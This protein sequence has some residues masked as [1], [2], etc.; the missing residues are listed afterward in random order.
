ML[1]IFKIVKREFLTKVFTRGFIISTILGPV[2]MI[3]IILAPAYFITLGSDK[4]VRIGILDYTATFGEPL[5]TTFQD[6]LNTGERKFQFSDIDIRDYTMQTVN[7]LSLVETGEFKGIVVIPENVYESDSV[8]FMAKTVSDL[9]LVQ[10]LRNGISSIVRQQRLKL[11]NLDPVKIGQLT[12]GISIYTIKVYEGTETARGFGEEYLTAMI[13]LVILYMTILIYGSSIMRSVIEEKSSRIIEI[14]LSSCNS[15][16][17]MMG[18][19]LGVGAVGLVQYVIWVTMGMGVFVIV[20]NTMPAIA[21]SIT[22]STTALLFFVIFFIIGFFTF[23]TLYA[24]VGAMCSDM[25]DAQSVSIPVTLLIVLPFLISFMVIRDPASEISQILS[26]LP[27]FT[28]LI[29]F[30]RVLLIHPPGIE[31][32]LSILINLLTIV[33]IIWITAKI[34]RVG[35]LMYGKRATLPEILRWIKYR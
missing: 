12:R 14:L 23:S 1:K 10:R 30:L 32:F 4:P 24:A 34:Y 2:L 9:E 29:M 16:Q 20:T 13:F 28:P 6:T 26:L 17:L 19:L 7:Y 21:E 33:G 27:F 3:A 15:F 22:F 25:Q 18:K 35:I 31:I 11:E 5:R 8:L